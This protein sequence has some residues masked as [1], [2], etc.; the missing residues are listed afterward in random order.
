[1]VRSSS[2]ATPFA[3]PQ[4]RLKSQHEAAHEVKVSAKRQVSSAI[5]ATDR[6]GRKQ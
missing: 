3:T 2:R 1:M 6:N 5:T 4:L